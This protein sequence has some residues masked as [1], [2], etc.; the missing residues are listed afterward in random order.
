VFDPEVV[1][2]DSSGGMKTMVSGIEREMEGFAG[3]VPGQ[4]RDGVLPA[5]ILMYYAYGLQIPGFSDPRDK[6]FGLLGVV[7]ALMT[8]RGC[9]GEG[10][11]IGGGS[12]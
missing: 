3:H 5:R 7:K 6:V 12:G 1:A 9:G 8:L 4:G 10:D 2:A 11:D